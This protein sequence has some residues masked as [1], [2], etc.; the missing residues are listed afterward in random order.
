M[1]INSK[2]ISLYFGRAYGL[3]R[4]IFVRACDRE[5]WSLTRLTF[6]L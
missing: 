5:V 3:V 6:E 4:G 2:N 1:K